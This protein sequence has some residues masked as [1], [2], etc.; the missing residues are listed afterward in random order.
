MLI[1]TIMQ[2]YSEWRCSE[3]QYPK[4]II[5][6]SWIHWRRYYHFNV[7]QFSLYVDDLAYIAGNRLLFVEWQLQLV[8]ESISQWNNVSHPPNP[9]QY[10]MEK[11]KRKNP[12]PSSRSSTLYGSPIPVKSP[13]KFLSLILDDHLAY[14]LHIK[15]LKNKSW[16]IASPHLKNLGHWSRISLISQHRT[17]SI[18]VGLWLYS[19][20]SSLLNSTSPV[21]PHS[22][23]DDPY[24]QESFDSTFWWASIWCHF[25]YEG[26]ISCVQVIF[27]FKPQYL[28]LWHRFC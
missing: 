14:A 5:I 25:P 2:L 19:I 7:S 11:K 15:N 24:P 10:H 12:P 8:I 22:K 28:L 6:Y 18:K 3:G 4:W 16:S 27:A 23:W 17:N 20:W 9:H 26:N 21:R 1:C 13:V